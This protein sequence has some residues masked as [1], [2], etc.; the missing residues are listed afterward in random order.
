MVLKILDGGIN[1]LF[2]KTTVQSYLL[3]FIYNVDKCAC[4]DPFSA[5]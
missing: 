3:S 4:L 1:L 5:K 2:H